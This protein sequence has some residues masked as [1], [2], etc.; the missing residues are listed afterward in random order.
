[1]G[2]GGGGGGRGQGADLWLYIWWRV[3]GGGRGW[4]GLSQG[5]EWWSTH[6]PPN[7]GVVTSRLKVIVAAMVKL[8]AKWTLQPHPVRGPAGALGPL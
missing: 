8:P 3:G 2:V 7:L 6:V 4:R 1:M 5:R